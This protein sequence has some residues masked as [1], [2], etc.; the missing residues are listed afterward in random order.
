[1]N[2]S[3]DLSYK[4]IIIRSALG[5]STI[6]T[7]RL[8]YEKSVESPPSIIP[9]SRFFLCARKGFH[10][11]KLYLSASYNSA[12]FRIKFARNIMSYK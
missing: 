10:G 3:Y 9:P 12:L 11:L 8:L 6:K 5:G 7:P 2:I 1:M 4:L